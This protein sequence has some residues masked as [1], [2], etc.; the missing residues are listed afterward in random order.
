[1]ATAADN[2][3]RR[4]NRSIANPFLGVVCLYSTPLH[5]F[6]IACAVATLVLVFNNGVRSSARVT[7]MPAPN[8]C[9]PR[10][11]IVYRPVIFSALSGRRSP[12]T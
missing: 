10:R 5:G 7:P 3:I 1:M 11:V 8:I 9:T 6:H 12:T 4:K 2:E